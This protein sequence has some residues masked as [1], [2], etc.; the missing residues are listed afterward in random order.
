MSHSHCSSC[1]KPKAGYTCALCHCELC[2]RC[3]RFL[4][5]GTFAFQSNLA[6]EL[7]HS[8]YCDNC[9]ETHV[10]PAQ[11]HYAEILE[12]AK[13][14]LIFYSTQKKLPALL[15]KAPERVTVPEC[16]DRDE[17]IL[18][19]GFLAAEQ[20]FN[21]ITDVTLLSRV[22]RNGK[23]QKTYWRGSGHPAQIDVDKFNQSQDF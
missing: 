15:S 14:V 1:S 20:G 16:E 3:T 12:Q 5:E 22:E 13:E 4:G 18:H 6:A 9:F 17:L 23:H 21:S 10:A 19:L 2:K 8:S 7:Q 11:E